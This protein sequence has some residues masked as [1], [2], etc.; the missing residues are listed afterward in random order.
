MGFYDG[1]VTPYE[2]PNVYSN[3]LTEMIIICCIPT[4]LNKE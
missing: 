3:F 2:A 4:V 1:H